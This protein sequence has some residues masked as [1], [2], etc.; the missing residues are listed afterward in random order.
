M[1]LIPLSFSGSSIATTLSL[2]GCATFTSVSQLSHLYAHEGT[3]S[4]SVVASNNVSNQYYSFIYSVIN[5]P[6]L[7]PQFFTTPAVLSYPFKNAFLYV[8]FCGGTNVLMQSNF[9]E[10]PGVITYYPVTCFGD[11]HYPDKSISAVGVYVASVLCDTTLTNPVVTTTTREVD[12]PIPNALLVGAKIAL[13][14]TADSNSTNHYVNLKF[15]LCYTDGA[16]I[17]YRQDI[18]VNYGD[19]N[20]YSENLL[21][22]NASATDGT[23]PCPKSYTFCAT[24][25]ANSYTTIGNVTASATI[26]NLVN[27]RFISFNFFIYLYPHIHNLTNSLYAIPFGVSQ[28]VP[29]AS[30]YWPLINS[31][32][33]PLEQPIWFVSTLESGIEAQVTYWWNFGDG[34]F[35]VTNMPYVLYQYAN[36]GTYE[37]SLN[38]SNPVSNEQTGIIQ[39]QLSSG[40]N[41]SSIIIVQRCF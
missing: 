18:N 8:S 33:Y 15:A 17:P 20:S 39:N 27:S 13:I 3:Y 41:Q 34:T 22:C 32:Y 11:I 2:K 26:S 25:P 7:P 36:P 29:N 37:I 35:T 12:V 24:I 38:A 9:N 30:N 14:P 16:T 6:T 21:T 10:T 23:L 28:S 19:G 5:V 40:I 1:R 31:P 4:I